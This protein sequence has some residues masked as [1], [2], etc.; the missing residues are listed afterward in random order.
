MDRVMNRA[1]GENAIA[2]KN[3]QWYGIY[4][5]SV[6][7][8]KTISPLQNLFRFTR[9]YC[10]QDDAAKLFDHDYQVVGIRSWAASSSQLPYLWLSRW[11]VPSLLNSHLC[12]LGI[13]RYECS[14]NDKRMLYAT[15]VV[16]ENNRNHIAAS[17]IDALFYFADGLASAVFVQFAKKK[18]RCICSRQRI[19]RNDFCTKAN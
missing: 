10:I 13:V 1:A 19:S 11:T 3:N 15:Q 4:N 18:K 7:R 14:L 12:I 9:I 5:T 2:C 6:L 16:K 17:I 8:T